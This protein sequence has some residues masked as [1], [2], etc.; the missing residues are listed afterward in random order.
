VL[1]VYSL[2]E[3]LYILDCYRVILLYR[4]PSFPWRHAN[5]FAQPNPWHDRVNELLKYPASLT[6]HRANAV[7]PDD[8]SSFVSLASLG[9]YLWPA[10]SLSESAGHPDSLNHDNSHISLLWKSDF[11]E[12]ACEAWLRRQPE[13]PL[14]TLI[15]Y[16]HINLMLHANPVLIQ[17]FAHSSPQA[18]T[19][20]PQKNAV[21]R[22][23]HSWVHGNDYRIAQW[24]AE[25]L[26][27]S[28]ESAVAA[29]RSTAGQS[30]SRL[31]GRPTSP[32][33]HRPVFEAP[34]TPY[35]VYCKLISLINQPSPTRQPARR[36]RF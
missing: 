26:L 1:I 28:V 10:T 29:S 2:L 16:H 27:S 18:I 31:Q 23:V 19:R 15:V 8:R 14:T 24:H 17:R 20:D 11:V 22:A 4:P 6:L 7:T 25:Q 3:S 9:A 5:S 32:K 21:A 34:H 33:A 13:P 12:M 30:D 36:R 35:T